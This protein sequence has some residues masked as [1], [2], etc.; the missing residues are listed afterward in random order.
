MELSVSGVKWSVKRSVWGK[1]WSKIEWSVSGKEWSKMERSVS[2]K[3][4]VNLSGVEWGGV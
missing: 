1:E 2:G 4:K 3:N